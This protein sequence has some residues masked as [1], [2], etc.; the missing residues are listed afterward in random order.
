MGEFNA[1]IRRTS[2]DGVC[3]HCGRSGDHKMVADANG[4][5]KCATSPLPGYCPDG[6]VPF[7]RDDEQHV[8]GEGA[9]FIRARRVID[10]ATREAIGE[11]QYLTTHRKLV[12]D[13]A[14]SAELRK[15][16]QAVA[17]G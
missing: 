11:W 12:N 5:Y 1:E 16:A 10:K 6:Y 9:G 3:F 17:R 14:I 4:V 13:E 15:A 2:F 8:A 7:A